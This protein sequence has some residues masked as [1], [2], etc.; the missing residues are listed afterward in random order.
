MSGRLI[1]GTDAG[2]ASYAHYDHDGDKLTVE[3]VQD[4]EPILENAKARSRSESGWSH[5]RSMRWLAEIPGVIYGKLLMEGI[6]QDP[7]RLR[8]WL[9][10]P[11][12]RDFCNRN[13]TSR[14]ILIR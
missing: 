11:D 12:N 7:E 4:V 5:S 2:I 3:E 8:H 13:K 9:R 14:G 10:D 6:A 1:T